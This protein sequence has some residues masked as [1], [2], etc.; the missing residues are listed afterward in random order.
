MLKK[1]NNKGQ[2]TLEYAILVIIVI[3]ALISLSSYVKRGVQGRLKQ[4]SDDIGD[5]FTTDYNYYKKTTTT[6]HSEDTNS[7][8][9]TQSVGNTNTTTSMSL[10]LNTGVAN[11]WWPGR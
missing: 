3:A 4:S 1:K 6:S 8:G 7:K 5:Q 2:S 10:N 9:A 11:E